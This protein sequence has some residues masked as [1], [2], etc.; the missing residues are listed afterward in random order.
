MAKP[1]TTCKYTC[2][3]DH[4]EPSEEGEHGQDVDG[5]R[6][7][8]VESGWHAAV[9]VGRSEQVMAGYGD[10]CAVGRVNGAGCHGHGVRWCVDN[11]PLERKVGTVVLLLVGAQASAR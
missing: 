10:V 2:E 9:T 3:Q 1:K 6:R 4:D 5:Q 7:F 11:A 8:H